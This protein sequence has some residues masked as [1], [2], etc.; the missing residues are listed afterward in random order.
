MAKTAIINSHSSAKQQLRVAA[1][2]RV[3]TGSEEQLGSLEQQVAAYQH[4]IAANQN[5]V[6]AG[7]FAETASG[8]NVQERPAF[9]DL[10]RTCMRGKVDL[11]L[12]KSISRFGRN[13]LEMIRALRKLEDMG[14]DVYFETENLHL[15]SKEL[16]L[17]TEL[18]CAFAQWES[19]EKRRSI[20]WGVQRDFRL[21]RVYLLWLSSRRQG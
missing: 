13:T 14:V 17:V 11:I 6:D 20:K 10:L 1:Y 19:E 5:W 12:V 2:C 9:H 8:L 15:Q 16:R 18:Y 3:S 21:R 4:M 7:I